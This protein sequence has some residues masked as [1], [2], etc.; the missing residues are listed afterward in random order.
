[1]RTKYN[2]DEVKV[3]SANTGED[4]WPVDGYVKSDNGV[5]VYEFR[6]DKWHSGCPHCRQGP[7][8]RSWIEKKIDID[9]Q[10][11]KLEVMWECQFDQ[12]LASGALSSIRTT[13]PDIL[14]LHQTEEDL[15]RGI[16]E[17]RLYG[18]IICDVSTPT[19]IAESMADFPP[20]I[21]RLK[22]T[23]QH[24]S[25][26]MQG[27]VKSEKPDLKKFERETL[28]QCFNAKNHLLLTTLARYYMSKGMKLTNVTRF[29]Q[30]I[31]KKC[32][33]PFVERVT[34]MRIEAEL[35]SETTKGDTAKN[36]GNSGYGKVRY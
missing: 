14:E 11:F 19:D 23:E 12:L 32:L 33:A 9:Q 10:G 6:G 2:R 5:K 13:I 20:V 15:I 35:S 30:F 18:F 16:M 17:D 24:L 29:I 34:D 36:F 25:E 7:A 8:E 4:S 22:I 3:W 31:P 21:K 26:Y 1:M 28:V 27:R